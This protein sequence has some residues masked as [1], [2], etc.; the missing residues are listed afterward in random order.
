MKEPRPSLERVVASSE[1]RKD[2]IRA[3]TLAEFLAQDAPEL[4]KGE[5]EKTE[6]ERAIIALV[7]E[8]TNALRVK[9]GL[10][11]LDIPEK[12]FHVIKKK[13]WKDKSRGAYEPK[14]QGI[15]LREGA[16]RLDTAAS[17]F[18]E[19]VH[20][21]S[22]LTL[23]GVDGRIE[24]RGFGL[25]VG[26]GPN[27]NPRF[28]EFNEATT[29]ELTIRFV[30]RRKHDPL[31]ADE[32]DRHERHRQAL[33]DKTSDEGKPLLPVDAYHS[34]VTFKK[35]G[36]FIDVERPAY[37]NERRALHAFIDK[38]YDRNRNDFKD[39]EEVFDLFAKG[40]FTGKLLVLSRLI[41]KTFGTGTLRR[42][43]EQEGDVAGLEELIAKL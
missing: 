21:K 2:E 10:E 20:F 1:K 42:I 24:E 38:L 11:P 9:Y 18:H 6:T 13:E 29:E 33:G 40:M 36:V 27:R 17:A 32:T 41:E 30:E 4:V 35:H 34:R 12:I 31:F 37:A 16:S 25:S 14:L 8:E 28:S 19:A 5:R 7:N 26:V 22:Y 15:I 23:E 43:S 3:A 39:R